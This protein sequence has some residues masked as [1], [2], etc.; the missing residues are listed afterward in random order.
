MKQYAEATAKT[1]LSMFEKFID[2]YKKTK[3]NKLDENDIKKFIS[4][5]SKK[6]I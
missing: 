2:F 6:N 3:L 1:Y 4:H 5:Y